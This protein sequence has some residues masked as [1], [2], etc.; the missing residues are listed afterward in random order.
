MKWSVIYS[1]DTKPEQKIERFAP[2]GEWV[3]TE[4]DDCYDL[5][6]LGEDYEGGHHRKYCAYLSDEA[7]KKFLDN[8]LYPAFL[9]NT[10]GMLGSMLE[11]GMDYGWRPAFSFM[12]ELY[13]WDDPIDQNAYAF[14][15]PENEQETEFLQSFENEDALKNWIEEN[16]L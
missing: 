5:D 16:Y 12:P 14:P 2:E 4:E 1:V 8:T 11:D 3:L 9:E 6:Y 7:F 13:Q 15:F 10:M